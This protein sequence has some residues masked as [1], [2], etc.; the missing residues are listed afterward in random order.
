MTRRTIPASLAAL[1]LLGTAAC[2][3]SASHTGTPGGVSTSTAVVTSASTADSASGAVS[4]AATDATPAPVGGGS[5]A[6]YCHTAA[7]IGNIYLQIAASPNNAAQYKGQ[8][9]A[10]ETGVPGDI[11]SL[12]TNLHD[13]LIR[14]IDGGSAAVNQAQPQISQDMGQLD[15]WMHVHCS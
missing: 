9:D 15:T 13:A 7:G 10:I 1:A 12:I 8:V 3:S 14:L 5:D 4:S 2:S 11:S 6:G